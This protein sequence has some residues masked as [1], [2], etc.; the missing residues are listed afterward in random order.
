[1]V[2]AGELDKR[3]TFRRATIT[4]DGVNEQIK[5]W[6]DAC[7][8][9]A[10]VLDTDSKETYRA[11]KTHTET[12]VV[13]KVRHTE[14]INA[15]MRVKYLGREYAILGIPPTSK[16]DYLFVYAKEVA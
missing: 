2:K 9:W 4:Y 11:Q 10:A 1:M 6:A 7:T 3:I 13:F 15:R 12:S 14:K 5:T 8:V 16:R